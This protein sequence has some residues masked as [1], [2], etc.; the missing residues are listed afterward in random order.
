MAS[1]LDVVESVQESAATLDHFA[2]VFV[3]AWLKGVNLDR[4]VVLHQERP[5]FDYLHYPTIFNQTLLEE[6]DREERKC[7]KYIDDK[8]GDLERLNRQKARPGE[9]ISVALVIPS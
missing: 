4:A 8:L 3:P 6:M 7:Y 1:S 2:E 9:S 5:A